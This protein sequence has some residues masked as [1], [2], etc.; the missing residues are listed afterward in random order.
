MKAFRIL[1]KGW[2]VLA[3]AALAACIPRPSDPVE[4]L[5]EPDAVIIQMLEVGGLPQSE[6]LDRL[7]VP[8]F[9]L[10]GDGTLIYVPPEARA[11]FPVPDQ[12]LEVTQLS[13]RTV[14]DLLGDIVDYGF[15]NFA[16]EQ[17]R[18][19]S[20]Y[21][22]ATTYLYVNTKEG[23]NAVSAYAL[24]APALDGREW[25]EFRRLLEIKERLDALDLSS[26]SEYETEEF[27]LLV[28]SLEQGAGEAVAWPLDGIDLA[29]TAPGGT[30]VERRISANDASVLLSALG[31]RA[32]MIQQDGRIFEVGLR[33]LLPFEERFPEFDEP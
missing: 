19:G 5:Q 21:D 33:P 22:F 8:V 29:A 9:T 31:A 16:Y 10:Y 32:G 26:Q 15:L 28:Q 13:A 7:T 23:T 24:A 17:P 11:Q 18:P 20:R 4:W 14:R 25:R 3:L 12:P 27:V 6:L 1:G 30:I 2:P